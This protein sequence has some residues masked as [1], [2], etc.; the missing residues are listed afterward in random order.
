MGSYQPFHDAYAELVL[1]ALDNGQT[2]V[3]WSMDYQVKYGHFG[4]LLG[5]CSTSTIL[6]GS[7]QL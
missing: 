4:W 2:K 6:S 3:I 5:H 1:K 7:R